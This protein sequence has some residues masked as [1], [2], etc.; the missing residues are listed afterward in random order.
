MSRLNITE[1]QQMQQMQQMQQIHNLG[2]FEVTSNKL[3]VGDPCYDYDSDDSDG[4]FDLLSTIEV[5]NGTWHAYAYEGKS[6]NVCKIVIHRDN[7]QLD[8]IF[9]SEVKMACVGV[10][11]GQAGF[12]DLKNYKDDFLVGNSKIMDFSMTDKG[13]KWYNMCCY[14]TIKSKICGGIVPYGVV[15]QS[16]YGD[17]Y[18]N[19]FPGY[20]KDNFDESLSDKPVALQIIFVDECDDECDDVNSNDNE[21]SSDSEL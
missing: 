9:F 1:I 21:K 11:S 4:W 6:T 3:L 19:V 10:D 8:D 2:T 13:A 5:D 15:S 20:H 12:F 14:I 18:Y 17:G 16:G 7:I